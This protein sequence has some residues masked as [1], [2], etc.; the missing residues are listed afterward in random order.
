MT[1]RME[2]DYLIIGAGPAGLQL[3]YFLRK[4]GRDF[5]ILETGDSAGTFL[6]VSSSFRHALVY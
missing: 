2:Y 4:L 3:G 1:R 5:L 6:V